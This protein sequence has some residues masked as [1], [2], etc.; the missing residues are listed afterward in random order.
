MIEVELP[1]NATQ[2]DN[3]IPLHG[4]LRKSESNDAVV[5]ADIYDSNND[6][7]IWKRELPGSLQQT[8]SEFIQHNPTFRSS[9]SISSE[10]ASETLYDL[11]GQM[12]SKEFTDDVAT[13]VNMFCTLFDLEQAGVRLSVLDNAMCPKFHVDRIPCRLLTTYQGVATEWLPSEYVYRG[14]L[15]HGSK[16]KPDHESGLYDS[17]TRIQQLCAGDVALLKGDTWH[18]AE[19]NGVV[20]RSPA[21]GSERRLL[22]TI[23]I[24]N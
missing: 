10:Q 5:L 23:D 13:L 15:G 17:S 8:V 14:K 7:A 3:V 20:H 4:N 6:I 9:V 24:I 22:L 1:D 21:T 19:G 16:G 18:G 2:Y 11:F 12:T